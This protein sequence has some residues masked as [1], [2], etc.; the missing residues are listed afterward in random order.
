MSK[1]ENTSISFC[2][3]IISFS[4]LQTFSLS[5]SLLCFIWFLREVQNCFGRH[6]KLKNVRVKCLRGEL[7]CQLVAFR[8]AYIDVVII[9]GPFHTGILILITVLG[10]HHCQTK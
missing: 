8:I 2:W 7:I 5:L 4:I 10:L 6:F 1:R 3:N 9:G